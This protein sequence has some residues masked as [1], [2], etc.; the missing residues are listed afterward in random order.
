[1]KFSAA[2]VLVARVWILVVWF[3]ATNPLPARVFTS[4]DGKTFVGEITGVSGDTVF[5]RRVPDGRR[6]SVPV[7]RLSQSDQDYIAEW[8]VANPDLKLS[9]D[10]TKESKTVK[11]EKLLEIDEV[12]YKI[13]IKNNS[14][15]ETPALRLYYSQYKRTNDPR[16]SGKARKR[17]SETRSGCL[18][19]PPIDGFETLVLNAEPMKVSV[20]TEVEERE[21]P[22]AEGR[23]VKVRDYH[24]VEEELKGIN[25]LVFLKEREVARFDTTAVQELGV[26]LKAAGFGAGKDGAAP[27]KQGGGASGK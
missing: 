21:V 24:K 4:P 10:V 23:R 27:G 11:K 1:M 3:L 7:S 16:M 26:D 13:T 20:I 14:P 2:R 17:I 22:D 12:A 5:I 8:K 25:F 19:I 6:F 18:E 9:F 15:D